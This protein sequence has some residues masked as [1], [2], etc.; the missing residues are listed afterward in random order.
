METITHPDSLALRHK[1]QPMLSDREEL[2][3]TGQPKQGL[4]LRPYDLFLIPFSVI[5]S[6]GFLFGVGGALLS[7]APFPF[8]FVFLFF[9]LVAFYITLG[10]F[11]MDTYSRAKTVYGI[12][13]RRIIVQNEGVGGKT[14]SYDLKTLSNLSLEHGRDGR[15]TVTIGNAPNGRLVLRGFGFPGMGSYLPPALEMIPDAQQVYELIQDVRE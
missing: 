5:W 15:G 14:H 4:L 10:R 6:A 13:N 12:T 3:W 9:G 7:G 2:L 1:L 11:L 8:V